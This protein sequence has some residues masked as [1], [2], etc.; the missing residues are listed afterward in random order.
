MY[1]VKCGVAGYDDVCVVVGDVDDVTVTDDGGVDAYVYGGGT[2]GDV[3]V[4]I[5]V[6]MYCVCVNVL[7]SF[8]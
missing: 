4:E 3:Y 7:L 8:C 5:G 6:A 1:V 2:V